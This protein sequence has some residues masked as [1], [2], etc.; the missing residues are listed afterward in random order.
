MNDVTVTLQWAGE[1]GLIGTA[2]DRTYPTLTG[3]ASGQADGEYYFC[4]LIEGT[5]K[6]IATTP[7]RMTPTRWDRGGDDEL[8]S[9]GE[10]FGMD[11][12]MSMETFEITDVLN[13]LTG[14]DGTG[15]NGVAG[16]GTFPDNQVDESHDFGFA[17]LDY[18]DLP[19][20]GTDYHTVMAEDGA[21]HVIY[22]GFYLGGS[23]DAEREGQPTA[24]ADGDDADL[25]DDED[26]IVFTTPM[27]P[28]YE[29][30]IEV[31]AENSTGGDAVL[32]GWI[33][34]DGDGV[35]EA[36]EELVFTGGNAIAAGTTTN[37]EYCFEVPADAKYMQGM[38]MARFRLSANGGL[39]PDGPAKYGD[40]PMPQ[41]EVEDYKV[42]L[43]KVG[44]LIWFDADLAGDQNEPADLGH[45]ALSE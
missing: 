28:G 44:N 2:D 18:G 39:T 23:V 40:D 20:A 29:A 34:W 45:Q 31:S 12:T 4:G 9:D 11:L 16:V 37:A 5:Y 25:T 17:F 26:G 42:N 32:Q 1:D 15:D 8:D 22:P 35:L 6:L 10:V 14:E 13:M 36:S 24:N 38:A 3:P 30:C 43:G 33:D 41:G 7:D 19:D 21:V 27:I